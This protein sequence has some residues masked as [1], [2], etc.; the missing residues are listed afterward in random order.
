MSYS[1]QLSR[2]RQLQVK[3][4]RLFFVDED[5][6]LS[7]ELPAS[8][9]AESL[10]TS[11]RIFDFEA[12]QDWVTLQPSGCSA[13]YDYLLHEEGTYLNSLYVDFETACCTACQDAGED[14][15]ELCGTKMDT[16]MAYAVDWNAAL[17]ATSGATSYF[18]HGSESV[19]HRAFELT[20]F[21]NLGGLVEV[22]EGALNSEEDPHFDL[23]ELG[24]H[25]N[26]DWVQC[27]DDLN[28]GAASCSAWE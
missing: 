1:L 8:A 10:A 23:Q 13:A 4:Y 5:T 11:G 9:L 25:A 16:I 18:E 19:C 28:N 3:N 21:A 17:Y 22:S 12:F 26:V 7:E 2:G 15:K 24:A 14:A 6:A 20:V 27:I